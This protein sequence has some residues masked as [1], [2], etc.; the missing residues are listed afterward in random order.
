MA[1]KAIE[2]VLL[3]SL[4]LVLLLLCAKG[5]LS[6][7]ATDEA[8]P[9]GEPA[10]MTGEGERPVHTTAWVDEKLAQDGEV[11]GF[12]HTIA[13]RHSNYED[14]R[15]RLITGLIVLR[16]YSRRLVR[17]QLLCTRYIATQ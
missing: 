9:D 1:G 14:P 5:V 11:D 12:A 4:L 17:C 3:G 8:G 2:V 16:L 10:H 13:K 15:W 6:K 7:P